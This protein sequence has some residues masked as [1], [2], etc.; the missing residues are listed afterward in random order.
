[1]KSVKILLFG[2]FW[3][4]LLTFSAQAKMVALSF[5][6]DAAALEERGQLK[7]LR[8]CKDEGAIRLNDILLI[9]DDG[10]ACGIPDNY[11][12][13]EKAWLEKLQKGVTV[14]KDFILDD[15]RAFSG[16]IVFNGMEYDDNIHPLYIS[17]NGDTFKRLPTRQAFPFAKQYIDLGS[18]RWFFIELPV[19]ALK[20]GANKILLWTESEQPSWEINIAAE[21]EFQR[22]S[23]TRT[24]HPNR[25]AKSLDGG[26]TWDWKKLG[27]KNKIDGEY[28]IRLSL[29]RS[30]PEGVY[31]SPVIDLAEEYGKESIKELLNIDESFLIWNID[32]P[33][34]SE[35]E[36][37][38][39]LG[40]SPVPTSKTWSNYEKVTGDSF[41]KK[42]SNPRGRY[43]Q[44]RVVMKA[45]NPLVTPT[46]KGLSIETKLEKIQV[47]T[48]V[49]SR[50]VEL[51]NGRVT[52]PSY[53]F[54]DEDYM[55][56]KLQNYRKS[57]ELD[58]IVAGAQ[59]EFE[60]ILKLLRWAYEIPLVRK[61][62]SWQYDD[63]AILKKNNTGNII[64]QKDYPGRRRDI[65]CLH[66]N[67]VLMGACL[68]FG[69]PAKFVNINSENVGGHEVMEVWS[70][71]FNKWIHLDAT[72]DFYCYDPETGI[73]MSMIEMNSRLAELIPRQETWQRPFKGEMPSDSIAYKARVAWREGDN[74]F[75]IRDVNQGPHLLT[76]IGH[77]RTPFRNDFM[78]RELPTPVL[79][80]YTMW[81]WSGFLNYYSETFPRR[82]E[83]QHHTNRWQDFNRPLNQSELTLSKTEQ[84]GVFQIDVDT[85]TPCFETFEIKTDNNKWKENRT[86]TFKWTLHEGMNNLRVR[87]RNTMG[88]TGPESFV[89]VIM[90]N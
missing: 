59:T 27:W 77:F 3:I 6:L 54:T 63:I 65:M 17:V 86:S 51:R 57:F 40:E 24:H 7:E 43:L 2:L 20:Q 58:K 83:Y 90:N 76:I 39:R 56:K 46:L 5:D 36:I 75:S 80:G 18:N 81:G 41:T 13:K 19:G 1:M 32:V 35:V 79:Q 49:M 69:F 60:T 30:V 72:R 53:E 12:F 78:S 16:Y 9:E 29:D 89:S 52:R 61:T 33:E 22:G 74:R 50:I 4:F 31:T 15:P 38:T 28:S 25:S 84:P 87:I 47:E 73:P 14:R 37:S 66:S 45:E 62:Y 44:F 34:G 48:N 67:Q 82:R 23:L 55:N 21:E 26:N 85:E 88:V 10:P 8:Y 68:A 11:D 71:E 42:L 64:L 70:N